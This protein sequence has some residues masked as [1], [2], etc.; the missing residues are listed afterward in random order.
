MSCR[1]LISALLL[2]AGAA[3]P[4]QARDLTI[5]LREGGWVDGLRAVFFQPFTAATGLPLNAQ[6]IWDG[7]TENLR[8][9][10]KEDTAG[11]DVILTN[12]PALAAGCDDGFLEKL[13]WPAIG[14]KEHYLPQAV[15]D[16]G[17]GAFLAASVLAWDREKFPVTPGWSEF[18]DVAKVPG[19]RGL[20]R[21][22]RGTLEFALL[23]D[24]VALGD[25]YK[26]MRTADGVDRAFRRLDQLR[27]FIVWWQTEAEA[28]R[29]LGSGEVLMTSAAFAT[30]AAAN[31][32]NRQKFGVQWAGGLA[33]IQHWA[34]VKGSPNLR[35]AQQFLYF[36]GTAAI[37]V[38]LAG[39]GGLAKGVAELRSPEAQEGLV[40]APGNL[41][42]LLAVDEGF[43][44]E[45]GDKLDTRFA[46]WLDR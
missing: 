14:G 18:W 40:S 8:T 16:C 38:R 22:P 30:I 5:A 31:R 37:Q 7:R 35:Q 19:K 33:R 46:A 21:N 32:A 9:H 20:S 27:A 17:V 34:I 24:G 29:L 6:L 10:L 11:W 1:S 42:A 41:A 3:L 13:D 23:A 44:R 36:A 43:W 15:S 39:Y 45:Q 2:L 25:V 28:V 4:A 12:T 26:L